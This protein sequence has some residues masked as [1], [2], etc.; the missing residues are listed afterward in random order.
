MISEFLIVWIPS[1]VVVT[2]AYMIRRR[3]RRSE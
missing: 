3:Y 1:I 2:M